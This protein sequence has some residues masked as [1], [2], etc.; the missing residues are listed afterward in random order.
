M[1]PFI[2]RDEYGRCGGRMTPNFYELNTQNAGLS[3]KFFHTAYKMP[4]GDRVNSRGLE[5]HSQMKALP[6]TLDGVAVSY[7]SR[8]WIECVKVATLQDG[9]FSCYFA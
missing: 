8:A 4:D 3:G 5:L 2:S 6:A 7:T 9:V 1:I